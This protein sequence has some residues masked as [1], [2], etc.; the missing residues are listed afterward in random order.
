M[1]FNFLSLVFQSSIWQYRTS[2]APTFNDMLKKEKEKSSPGAKT[3]TETNQKPKP[4]IKEHSSQSYDARKMPPSATVWRESQHA[5]S[6]TAHERLETHR[7]LHSPFLHE[8]PDRRE[9]LNFLRSAF[10]QMWPYDPACACAYISDVSNRCAGP[11]A[12][13]FES[14]K[15]AS[16]WA[17][18]R[19]ISSSAARSINV[20][21]TPGGCFL[22]LDLHIVTAGVTR[23]R[24][25]CSGPGEGDRTTR[26]F[27]CP[28]VDE[29]A[30]VPAP[31]PPPEM[32]SSPVDLSA[33]GIHRSVAEVA[34]PAPSVT[35]DGSSSCCGDCRWCCLLHHCPDSGSH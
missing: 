28:L 26:W 29:A 16:G 11:S 2:S 9:P 5:V 30:T 19:A 14:Q 4:I 32:V 7:S 20:L 22:D 31:D 10:A 34:A 25:C 6:T 18:V 33:A 15:T 35:T 3:K 12:S 24:C 27:C 1:V 23:Y 17:R 21:D 13:S 8:G